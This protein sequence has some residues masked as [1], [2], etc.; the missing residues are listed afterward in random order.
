MERSPRCAPPSGQR[1]FG[2][3]LRL[4]RARFGLKPRRPLFLGNRWKVLELL[5]TFV[6]QEAG[7][8][9]ERK[10][11]YSNTE[12]ECVPGRKV[13][14]LMIWFGVSVFLYFSC[15]EVVQ[16]QASLCASYSHLDHYG[17][18]RHIFQEVIDSGS[19]HSFSKGFDHSF[20]NLSDLVYR[21]LL[22]SQRWR[23]ASRM[24]SQID[25]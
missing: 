21:D 2:L 18:D 19:S 22:L 15:S 8:R 9:F 24:M 1:C 14:L 7:F 17:H 5:A 23:R 20:K 16:D 13:F 3:R 25:L 10:H 6:G 12:G 11:P 4:R